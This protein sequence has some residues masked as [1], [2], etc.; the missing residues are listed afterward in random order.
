MFLPGSLGLVLPRALL[1]PIDESL[2]YPDTVPF[3]GA[4]TGIADEVGYNMG[5]QIWFLTIGDIH[6]L[7]YFRVAD[8]MSP[9]GSLSLW[10]IHNHTDVMLVRVDFTGHSGTGWRAVDIPTPIKSDPQKVYVVA[11]WMPAID[12]FEGGSITVPRTENYFTNKGVLSEH[13]FVYAQVSNG[14]DDPAGFFHRNGL[15]KTGAFARPTETYTNENYWI[16]VVI[17]AR[18]QPIPP[19][20]PVVI[21]WPI[22]AGYPSLDN[23]G[24]DPDTVF[25][26]A[27]ETVN[28]SADGEVIEN[29]DVA[30]NI[31]VNHNNV[32]VQNC[33]VRSIASY[34]IYIGPLTSGVI[35][36]DCELDGIGRNNGGDNGIGVAG[37]DVQI[38][39]NNIY[40]IENG[41]SVFGG[42]PILIK[43]N[44]IH[45]LRAG[46]EHPHYDGLQCDGGNSGLTIEHNTIFVEHNDTS[47]IMIDNV[48]GASDD[49]LVTD[50][51]LAGA[52]Y[53]CYCDG[54]FPSGGLLTNIRYVR[55]IMRSGYYGYFAVN[56]EDVTWAG[57]QFITHC[58]IFDFL[59]P[60][61]FSVGQSVPESFFGTA[62]PTASIVGETVP[63]G[64]GLTLGL[65]FVPHRNGALT[66][67]IIFRPNASSTTTYK[68]GVWRW[69]GA[70]KTEGVEFLGAQ[71]FENV[72]RLQWVGLD[73]ATPIP[74]ASGDNLLVGVFIPRGSDGK[75][76]YLAN[77]GYFSSNKTSQWGRLTAFNNTGAAF[78]G[79][80]GCNGMYDY[81]AD[82]TAPVNA[83]GSSTN[84]YVDPV[85]TAAW[86]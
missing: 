72:I 66:G 50:N 71:T 81:A 20:P 47:A 46:P 6:K 52:G 42:P 2:W 69:L 75:V 11:L 31:V 70:N 57:N 24:P 59:P 78:N 40:R 29:L 54:S 19:I 13:R 30:S 10:T 73:L 74:V 21:K 22:P 27:L 17:N 37:V 9:N 51:Y 67:V 3:E 82:L 45:N 79:F 26:P 62:P 25:T 55:N 34:K 64:T 65:S 77:N 49:I 56:T 14:Q 44:F 85:F 18:P 60:G 53:T 28:S 58:S 83:G 63:A 61:G 43:D 80:I 12:T 5:A 39:R 86:S 38:L 8:V 23:T 76:W 68:I 35:V 36:Q 84:Y 16:D 15:F 7:C 33:K 1:D 32:T 48:S 41:I 4:Q